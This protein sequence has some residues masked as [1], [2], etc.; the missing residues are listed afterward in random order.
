MKT[1]IRLALGLIL[2]TSL[3][4]GCTKYYLTKMKDQ[5]T[6]KSTQL[7][8]LK[9]QNYYV[10]SK[11]THQFWLCDDQGD[12]LTCSRSCDEG[13]DLECPKASGGFG[14]VSTNTR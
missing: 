4:G 12:T 13:T 1:T 7:Q 3:F 5:G 2:V 8:F 14:G 11:V 9:V 10:Y 6:I